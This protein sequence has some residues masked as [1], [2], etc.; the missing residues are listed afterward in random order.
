MIPTKHR[1][2]KPPSPIRT[3]RAEASVRP[4]AAVRRLLGTGAT[5]AAIVAATWLPTACLNDDPAVVS[6]VSANRAESTAST[7]STPAADPQPTTEPTTEP[8]PAAEQRSSDTLVAHVIDNE[9]VAY[10]GPASSR[11]ISSFTNPNRHGTELVFQVLAEPGSGLVESGWL[12]VLLPMRPNGTVGWIRA[13]E[14]DL[15][16]N[17]YRIE[18]DVDDFTLTVFRNDELYFRTVVGIGEGDTPT[19][20]GSFYLTDLLRPSDPTGIYGP[21]A[22]GLSGFSE[23]LASFNGGAGVIGIHGTNQ[24]SALGTRVSHGCIRVSNTSISEMATFLP[25]GTPVTIG[26]EPG[27]HTGND[28]HRGAAG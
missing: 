22:Y 2:P 8:E 10:A 26:D 4:V 12:P 15:T 17:P 16:R 3:S 25:L 6:T 19:P 21:Y 1:R 18:V 23:S 27:R 7:A 11:V 5:L 24:P 28:H 13:E 20:Y 9:V 14:V